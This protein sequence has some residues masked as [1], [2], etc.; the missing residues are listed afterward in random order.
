[1]LSTCDKRMKGL[2]QSIYHIVLEYA[3]LLTALSK[4]P[5][6]ANI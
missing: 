3:P 2:R 5:T 4:T 6:L 1:M